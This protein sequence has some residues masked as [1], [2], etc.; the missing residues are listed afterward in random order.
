M[1]FCLKSETMS[2]AYFNSPVGILAITGNDYCITK[3]QFVEDFFARPSTVV[4]EEVKKCLVEL[5]EYFSLHR[6]L[7]TVKTD[8]E[9]SEFKKAIW[10]L[11]PSIEFGKTISY[12][13]L[14][15][16]YGDLYSVRAVGKANSCNPLVIVFPCHRVVGISGE[17]VGYVGGLEKKRWLLE[18][19]KAIMPNGQLSLF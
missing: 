6:Q 3:V 17:L 7:F 19:E 2:L 9:G 10:N 11:L 8:P 16:R 15:K 5:D 13:E 14:A 4:G 12:L 1:V 18:H